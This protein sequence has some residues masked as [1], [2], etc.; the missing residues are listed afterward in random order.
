MIGKLACVFNYR[1]VQCSNPQ[2]LTTSPDRPARLSSSLTHRAPHPYLPHPLHSP[3]SWLLDILTLA[4]LE[5]IQSPGS[6][7]G[8]S[9]RSNVWALLASCG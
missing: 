5:R 6:S 2:E 9:L 4:A 1:N 3:T 7:L 8:G